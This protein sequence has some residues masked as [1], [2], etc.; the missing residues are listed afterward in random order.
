[1][2]GVIQLST[3]VWAITRNSVSNTLGC[4]SHICITDRWWL[5]FFLTDSLDKASTLLFSYLSMC[6]KGALLNR[7]ML[8][9]ATW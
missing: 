2:M 4:L 1:M 6:S 3:S 5:F 8:F 9:Q 7:A